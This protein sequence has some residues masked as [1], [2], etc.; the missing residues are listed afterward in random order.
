M[1]SGRLRKIQ[2]AISD[3]NV[4]LVSFSIDPEHDTPAKLKDYANNMTADPARWFFLVGSPGDTQK[5][6][7]GLHLGYESPKDNADNG[8]QIVHS[9]KFLLVDKSGQVRGAYSTAD[10]ESMKK[11]EADARKLAAS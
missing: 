8:G 2:K 10:D 6:A 7:D 9:T 1:M 11:L 5:L 4:V 3:P